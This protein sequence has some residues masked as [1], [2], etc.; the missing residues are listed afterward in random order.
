MES[1]RE[2][3]S[4]IVREIEKSFYVDDFIS[5]GFIYVKVEII[6]LVF[7]EI[8][9]KGIFELYKWYLNVKELE[10]VCLVLVLEEEIYVKE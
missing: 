3:Y 6:K 10:I 2:K 4:E 8:F 5:G 9:V 1:C 7:V